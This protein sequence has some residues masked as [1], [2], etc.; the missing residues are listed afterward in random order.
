ME[1]LKG[2]ELI[3]G[4]LKYLNGTKMHLLS[5]SIV[6]FNFK[7]YVVSE[8]QAYTYKAVKDLLIDNFTAYEWNENEEY[9]I[10]I[11]VRSDDKFNYITIHPGGYITYI[12]D[13]GKSTIMDYLSFK[14]CTNDI[15]LNEFLNNFIIK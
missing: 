14:D 13:T 6:F 15:K 4:T 10:V 11:Q 8:E 9:E 7:A 12:K 3:N 5:E 2:K 1:E